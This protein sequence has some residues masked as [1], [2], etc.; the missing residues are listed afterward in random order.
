MKKIVLLCLLLGLFGCSSLDSPDLD[1]YIEKFTSEGIEIDKDEK[2][3][4]QLIAAE[5]GV[6]F[7]I[8]NEVVKI[9]QYASNKELKEGEERLPDMKKWKRNGLVVIETSNSK[10]LEIFDSVK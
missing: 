7:Y 9:Y 8:D 6:M 4:F 1:D 5:D 3:M 10:A 2:P